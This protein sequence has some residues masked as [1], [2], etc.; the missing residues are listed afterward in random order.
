[1]QATKTTESRSCWTDGYWLE[2]CEEFSVES[3]AGKLGYVA[4]VDPTHEELVVIGNDAVTRVPF[5]QIDFIDALGELIVLDTG[6]TE[7][8]TRR[9]VPTAPREPEDRSAGRS[10]RLRV[11]R[12]PT[13]LLIA[14]SQPVAGRAAGAAGGRRHLWTR[15]S[16]AP[17]TPTDNATQTRNA[18]V[19]AGRLTHASRR[20]MGSRASRLRRAAGAHTGGS[21]RA[22]STRAREWSGE[23]RPP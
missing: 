21:P 16:E 4:T 1:M 18:S 12:R 10:R 20:C 14:P 5:G 19:A 15:T 17:T 11:E 8:R 6:G 13:A 3:P 7:N 9:L 22:G 23:A 2:H